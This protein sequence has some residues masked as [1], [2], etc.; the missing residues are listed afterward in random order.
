MKS[1]FFIFLLAASLCV[2][3]YA[4]LSP[5]QVEIVDKAL[6]QI[7]SLHEHD[8]SVHMV[9]PELGKLFAA[10]IKEQST[11]MGMPIDLSVEHFIL[12]WKDGKQDCQVKLGEATP[13]RDMLEPQANNML[14]STG[15]GKLLS[16][17]TFMALRQTADYLKGNQDNIK[18]ENDS[19][20]NWDFAGDQDLGSFAG[21]NMRRIRFRIK[22]DNGS[23]IAFIAETE[24]GKRFRVLINMQQTPDGSIFY[25][26]RLKLDSNMNVNVQG[27]KLPQTINAKFTNYEFDQ[28]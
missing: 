14:S 22:K 23:L 20:A 18:L 21:Q 25:P 15:I 10:Q 27:I 7:S 24:E 4:Q 8:F 6:Q 1:P 28:K 17:G 9:S 19:E 26:D 2:S 5:E 16:E 12:I 13:M 3:L 11:K